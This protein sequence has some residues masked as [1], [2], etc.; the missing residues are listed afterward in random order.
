MECALQKCAQMRCIFQKVFPDSQM[1]YANATRFI[2]KTHVR[3]YVAA[4]AERD[5][6]RLFSR[7]GVRYVP[8]DG[9]PAVSTKPASGD[10]TILRSFS[11]QDRIS[12]LCSDPTCSYNDEF[13]YKKAKDVFEC[14]H[15]RPHTCSNLP[16][17]RFH[18]FTGRSIPTA[19]HAFDAA[20]LAPILAPMANA[21][22][23]GL[24]VAL[25]QSALQPYLRV[26][27]EEKFCRK[28]FAHAIEKQKPKNSIR[29]LAA[30]LAE[31]EENCG[32]RNA[33]RLVTSTAEEQ[34][35]VLMRKAKAEH[36]RQK[37]QTP[38]QVSEELQD[39]L[40]HLDSA[41]ADARYYYAAMLVF[42]W[43]RTFLAS[44][45]QMRYPIVAGTDAGHCTSKAGGVMLLIVA[46]DANRQVV[47]LA[48][49]HFSDNESD[50]TWVDF[51]AFVQDKLPE[52]DRDLV[53]MIRDGRNS[54]TKALNNHLR[55][56]FRF[57]CVKHASEAAAH[58][59][60]GAGIISA[61][62][63][64][65]AAITAGRLTFLK[66][67]ATPHALLQYLQA[68]STPESQRLLAP[69]G[70]IGG[71]MQ[72]TM[73]DT[74]DSHHIAV[75]GPRTTNQFTESMMGAA[76]EDG[77]RAMEPTEMVLKT[78]EAHTQRM[79]KRL[80]EVE[81]CTT[82]GTPQVVKMLAN[83]EGNARAPG[84]TRVQHM[85]ASQSRV[86]PSVQAGGNMSHVCDVHAR[87]C[88]CGLTHLTDFPCQELVCAA[89]ARGIA[90]DSLLHASDTAAHW[91]AQ[92]AFNYGACACASAAVY[93][94]A[95]D[96]LRMPA[97][98]PNAAGR[99]KTS[100]QKSALERAAGR[101]PAGSDRAPR[102][103]YTC[104]KCGQPKKGHTCTG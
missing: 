94:R 43:A 103:S 48:W 93:E 27:P 89:T 10:F 71:C 74:A 28:V 69:F 97:A 56:P 6:K 46:L 87:T 68:S 92:H 17:Q 63:K 29:Y 57:F 76:K 49:A 82:A 37:I 23:K 21:Q 70:A 24:K 73:S 80:A 90:L 95:P 72:A 32:Y 30:C 102:K 33:T 64:M 38:F 39:Q 11:R 79:L 26:Q 62:T 41:P 100:R 22:K 35:D 85:S 86:W 75:V 55:A 47:P 20:D 53:T 61:Y 77:S 1:R 5:G 25:L 4:C 88:T 66:N 81:A 50:K 14:A 52:L 19:R 58:T 65:A 12:F 67:T 7:E 44:N 101:R 78:V 59:V 51:M 99:P 34:K 83:L 18:P 13:R 15:C 104:K 36:Q 45:F 60:R 91:R 96:D 84:R 8:Q 31:L 9:G 16:L 40:G 2:S 3:L 54:I 42:P 98:L